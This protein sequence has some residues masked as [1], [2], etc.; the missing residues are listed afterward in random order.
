MHRLVFALCFFVGVFMTKPDD[1]PEQSTFASNRNTDTFLRIVWK[2]PGFAGNSP[3][4]QP[5]DVCRAVRQR[6]DYEQHVA[7]TEQNAKLLFKVVEAIEAYEGSQ[8]TVGGELNDLI[9]KD[10]N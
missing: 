3:G 8:P 2:E 9:P 10:P 6:L 4:V 7:P 1:K 5:I